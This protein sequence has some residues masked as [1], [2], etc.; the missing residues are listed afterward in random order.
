PQPVA[1]DTQESLDACASLLASVFQPDERVWITEAVYESNG[2]VWRV[3]LLCPG[4]R[5]GWAR[6]RYRYD[7]PSGTLHF[8]GAEPA[9]DDDLAAARRSGRQI[10][11]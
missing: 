8:A 7:I 2:P 11:T 3:T 1:D 5:S 6:R 4:E 9:G 10:S